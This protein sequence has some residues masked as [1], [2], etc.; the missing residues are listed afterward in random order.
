MGR[1]R[2]KT[3]CTGNPS[4]KRVKKH[5]G[6]KHL[7]ELCNKE[8]SDIV[9]VICNKSNGFIDLFSQNKDPDWLFLLMKTTVKVSNTEFSES[10]RFILSEICQ[11]RRFLDHLLS[12][13]QTSPTEINKYRR[14]NMGV[15]YENCL[16]VCQAITELFQKT[17]A[18]RLNMLINGFI[19]AM[20][21]IQKN[22]CLDK[23]KINNDVIMSKIT[24]ILQQ[25]TNLKTNNAMIKTDKN[26]E[27]NFEPLENFRL[28]SVYPI[29][30]DMDSGKPF[31]RPNII[32]GAY[33]SVEHYLDVQFRLLREDFVAPLRNGIQCYKENDRNYSDG[34]KKINDIHIYRNVQFE[35]NSTFIQDKMGYTINFNQNNRL[36]INWDISKRFMYGSLLIFTA[37]EFNHFFLGVVLCR[38]KQFLKNGQ[39]VVEIINN[40]TPKNLQ[41]TFTMAESKVY[42][43]PYKCAMEVL[44]KMNGDNFPMEKYIVSASNEID[45]PA[46]LKN[47]PGKTYKVEQLKEFN[48]LNDREWPPK[49][50]LQLDEMQYSAF[51]AA[52]TKELA[53]IQGP[54]GTGKTYIGLKIMETI[55]NN[56]YNTSLIKKPIL[57]V[58]YTNHALDQFCEGIIQFTKNIVRIGGQT[59][60]SIMKDYTLKSI[61]KYHRMHHNVIRD[62]SQLVEIAVNKIKRYKSCKEFISKNIG[63]VE[64]SLLKKGMPTSYHNFFND[65]VKYLDWLFYD[66][67]FFSFDPITLLKDHELII[68]STNTK[69]FLETKNT[70]S[71]EDDFFQY[72]TEDPDMNFDYQDIVVYS[73][74]LQ[75]IQNYCNDKIEQLLNMKTRKRIRS[76]KG[77][78]FT[79]FGYH[80]FRDLCENLKKILIY[81][82]KMLTL[83][84]NNNSGFQII[85]KDIFTLTMRDRW[86]LYFQWVNNTKLVF[87]TKIS[88][89][90]KRYV[91]LHRQYSEL[92]EME[93]IEMLSKKH[94]VAMTTTGASKHRVLLEGLQSPIG[95]Y[96]G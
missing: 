87:D 3:N 35:I 1:K 46:Y 10:K 49:E 6:F 58:C 73:L 18:E 90:E 62:L 28:L 34:R 12:Y 54:P 72:E 91:G 65:P 56:F 24:K 76:Y 5:F 47:L 11:N 94:V 89:H 66:D 19:E 83:A 57:V 67:D 27:Q 48:V 60:S 23:I 50:K 85:P 45:I 21:E 40:V 8:P 64:L 86:S 26:G 4:Q 9:F 70:N 16:T 30:G 38:D 79:D 22:I 17:A 31:L 63:I 29:P 43:E 55:I 84:N 52:L 42:F 32:E 13:I 81:F 77:Q 51:K 37:D 69:T 68:Q 41:S 74:T 95:K 39:L 71:T 53:V 59:K 82:S 25:F 14:E 75:D 7:E 88:E 36:K 78:Y 44:I 15:F 80:Q 93:C 2:N 96:V 33:N 92:K 20:S 61:T